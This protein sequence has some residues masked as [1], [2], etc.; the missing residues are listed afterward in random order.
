MSGYGVYGIKLRDMQIPPMPTELRDR[1]PYR[2]LSV[3]RRSQA[4]PSGCRGESYPVG[5]E[6]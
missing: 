6:A 4:C 2:A 1:G 5:P 3:S